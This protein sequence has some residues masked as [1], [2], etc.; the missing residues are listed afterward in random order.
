MHSALVFERPKTGAVPTSA[1]GAE[2]PL[3]IA[4]RQTVTTLSALPL[5]AHPPAPFLQTA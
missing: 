4:E 5:I 1:P 3:V 2:Q